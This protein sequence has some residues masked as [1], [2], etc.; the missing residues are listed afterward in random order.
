MITT[1]AAIASSKSVNPQETTPKNKTNNKITKI[2]VVI[3]A[4]TGSAIAVMTLSSVYAAA[5]TGFL[6]FTATV[7]VCKGDKPVDKKITS[8]AK[9]PL[10]PKTSSKE[11]TG[12]EEPK[13]QTFNESL[14]EAS[15][16]KDQ[17]LEKMGSKLDGMVMVKP[18]KGYTPNKSEKVIYNNFSHHIV[19]YIPAQIDDTPQTSQKTENTQQLSEKNKSTKNTLKHP[20]LQRPRQ[21]KKKGQQNK[22]VDLS[23]TNG[24]VRSNAQSQEPSPNSSPVVA[25]EEDFPPIPFNLAQ[26]K[27]PEPQEFTQ[28][29]GK[30]EKGNKVEKK[31]E[32]ASKKTE[33]G[34]SKKKRRKKKKKNKKNNKKNKSV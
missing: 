34:N 32:I 1:S 6:L 30:S 23:K 20:T 4:I 7:F 33:A 13:K 2:V 18:L 17:Y 10:T 5:T 3:L 12:A 28:S 16:T 31:N 19:V 26:P 25:E 11:T 29:N 8:Q 24:R 22:E 15:K 14:I 9:K 21:L 27:A